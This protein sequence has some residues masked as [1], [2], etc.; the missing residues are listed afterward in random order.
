MDVA[1]A[2]LNRDRGVRVHPPS[3]VTAPTR[4][5]YIPV[6]KGDIF[7][8]GPLEGALV[9]YVRETEPE[10]FFRPQP[11]KA[12]Q[13]GLFIPVR[14]ITVTQVEAKAFIQILIVWSDDESYSPFVCFGL[15]EGPYK[16]ILALH[17]STTEK[18]K[19]RFFF[20]QLQISPVTWVIYC[21]SL[22]ENCE[23]VP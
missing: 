18:K 5:S 15:E 10:I 11:N 16:S 4:H 9:L 22:C 12:S 13:I 17:K 1:N 2:N 7:T 23:V 21:L 6:C 8:I 19:K 14:E 20:V 3:T